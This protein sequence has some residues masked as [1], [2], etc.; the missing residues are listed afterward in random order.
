[1]QHTRHW[2]L[3]Q[4]R[5][6]CILKKH[7]LI[8]GGCSTMHDTSGSVIFRVGQTIYIRCIYG[9]SGR[10]ITKY[11]VIYG[12]YIRFWPTLVILCACQ[13]STFLEGEDA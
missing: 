8:R 9:I 3:F 10:E 11:T 5:H 13:S 12:A 2:V 7:V 4:S 6:V 1:M